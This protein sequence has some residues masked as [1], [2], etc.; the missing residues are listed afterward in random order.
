MLLQLEAMF[1]QGLDFGAAL[2][3][4]NIKSA[5]GIKVA[6]VFWGVLERIAE[7][8]SE[9]GPGNRYAPQCPV[10]GQRGACK[11]CRKVEQEPLS[12]WDWLNAH[13]PDWYR[14]REGGA[15]Q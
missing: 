14:K 2:R 9:P 6:R 13:G 8:E 1:E 15:R 10:C 5:D 11:T 7:F 4:A 3:A 12:Q